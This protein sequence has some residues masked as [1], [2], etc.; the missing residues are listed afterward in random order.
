MTKITFITTMLPGELPITQ[1][2]IEIHT[3]IQLQQSLIRGSGSMQHPGMFVIFSMQESVKGQTMMKEVGHTVWQF[4][5]SSWQLRSVG[6][7]HIGDRVHVK[8]LEGETGD[9]MFGDII[10]FCDDSKSCKIELDFPWN[11]KYQVVFMFANLEVIEE[12]S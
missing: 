8:G 7:F 6:G 12:P 2:A 5:A 10:L 4:S 1:K 3:D 9:D 11:G